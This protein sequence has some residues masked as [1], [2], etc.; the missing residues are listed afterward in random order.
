[1]HVRQYAPSM[2]L[3]VVDD[4]LE[5]SNGE[6]RFACRGDVILTGEKPFIFARNINAGIA[7]A[8][9]DDVVLLNDD[10]LL[11][12]PGGFSLLRWA[13]EWNREFGLISAATNVCNN[14]QQHARGQGLRDAGKA[15][16][17]VSVYIPR[18]TIDLVGP[19]DERFHGE[20]DG[21]M[22]YGGEDT[23]YCY[24]VRRNGLKIGV[25]DACFVDHSKLKSTFRPDGRGLSIKATRTR[26]RAIH[27]VEMEVA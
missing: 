19:L 9:R 7:A 14:P 22:I 13:S 21:E 18:R 1:M 27:G 11:E 12:T 6:I 23:D 25:F 3:I 26:F 17:F 10:A 15:V 2:R 24:R 5:Y 16:A 20:I 8:G 4:G